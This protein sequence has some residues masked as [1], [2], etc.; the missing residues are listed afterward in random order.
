MQ[1]DEF[2]IILLYKQMN[3]IICILYCSII[4]E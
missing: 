4:D 3:F 1:D 2:H